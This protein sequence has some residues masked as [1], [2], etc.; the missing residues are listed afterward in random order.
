ML[1]EKSGNDARKAFGDGILKGPVRVQT[2]EFEELQHVERKP[3]GEAQHLNLED[4]GHKPD[5]VPVE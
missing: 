2:L 5:S 1:P 3:T 4:P